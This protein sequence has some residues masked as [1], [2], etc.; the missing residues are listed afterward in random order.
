MTF[1][2]AMDLQECQLYFIIYS[3]FYEIP[4]EHSYL[5]SNYN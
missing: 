1:Y 3:G 4:N 5:N 2:K